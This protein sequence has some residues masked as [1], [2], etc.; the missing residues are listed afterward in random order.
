MVRHARLAAKEH[1]ENVDGE[2]DEGGTDQ[3]LADGVHMRWKGKM[4]E[5][6]SRTENGDGER[7]AE[8]IEQAKPHAFAP[9]ALNAGDIGD[10][11][12]MVVVES[13]AQAKEKTG[14]KCKLKRGRHAGSKVRFCAA[15]C[16]GAMDRDA[17]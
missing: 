7:V 13:V 12:Q 9:V 5:D 16:K 11:G 3:P 1:D 10:C 4:K 6:D 8:G 17:C 15:A 14:D 2:D